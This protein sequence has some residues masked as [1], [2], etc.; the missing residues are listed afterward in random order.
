[1]PERPQPAEA[2]KVFFSYAHEDA[3]LCRRLQQHFSFLKR[4]KK[5]AQWFD[6]EI[7]PGEEWRDEIE[8]HLNSADVILLLISAAFANSD[9]CYNVETGRAME[10]HDDGL[11]RVVPIIRSEEHTSELQSHSFI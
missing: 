6:G 9:F 3:K 10:R 2:V 7:K 8:E 1:M 5:I 4:D 11:A